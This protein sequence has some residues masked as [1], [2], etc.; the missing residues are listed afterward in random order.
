MNIDDNVVVI[1]QKNGRKT[2]YISNRIQEV[3]NQVYSNGKI[4]FISST[5]R[6]GDVISIVENNKTGRKYGFIS[7]SDTWPQYAYNLGAL[8]KTDFFII[9]KFLPF[10]TTESDIG[11][12]FHKYNATTIQQDIE[13]STHY[14]RC[15]EATPATYPSCFGVPTSVDWKTHSGY[16]GFAI[17]GEL[18]YYWFDMGYTQLSN[19]IGNKTPKMDKLRYELYQVPTAIIHGIYL[20]FTDYVAYTLP[21]EI[22]LVYTYDEYYDP[23]PTQQASVWLIPL[24]VSTMAIGYYTVNE[25]ATKSFNIG[26][27]MLGWLTVT[28]T[29]LYAIEY[30]DRSYASATMDLTIYDRNTLSG[31]ATFPATRW[32]T[33]VY[34]TGS[35]TYYCN[36][37]TAYFSNVAVSSTKMAFLLK[38]YTTLTSPHQYIYKLIISDLDGNELSRSPW[39]TTSGTIA[40]DVPGWKY[41]SLIGFSTDENYVVSAWW[42]NTSATRYYNL[43][44]IDTW[45]V[46][47]LGAMSVAATQSIPNRLC[48]G[49]GE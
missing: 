46:T 26:K 38:G 5:S 2:A 6:V 40:I 3:G 8:Y 29:A 41:N 33:L 45:K 17:G 1:A 4:S 37:S 25:S 47:P 31:I 36:Q 27:N 28:S 14:I 35:A 34:D 9:P 16:Y 32:A 13:N 24:S 30:D 43:I 11:M 23:Y 20:A 7:F 19:Y 49:S 39:N 22:V 48:N 44:N 21:D 10:S 15:S 42:L 18:S 12:Y